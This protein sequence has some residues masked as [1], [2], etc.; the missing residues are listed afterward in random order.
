VIATVADV[1]VALFVMVAPV[2]IAAVFTAK[3]LRNA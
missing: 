3:P 1:R 2:L